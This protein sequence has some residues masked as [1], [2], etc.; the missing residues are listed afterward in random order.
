MKTKQEIDTYLNSLELPYFSPIVELKNS[1][2]IEWNGLIAKRDI[3]IGE[4][5][6]INFWNIVK[7]SIIEEIN[8]YY[9]FQN[10]LCIDFETYIIN[11]PFTKDWG[12][13]INHSCKPNCWLISENIIIA[14]LDIKVW[15]ECT[16]DYWTFETW[17][18]WKMECLCW[19]NNCRKIITWN[20]HKIK[21]LQ[22]N[23][24]KYFSPYLKKCL[25]LE[26]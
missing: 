23:L 15:D 5:L 12:W 19:E 10:N 18:D 9:D 14:I 3:K 11:K 7:K 17:S 21:E 25:N 4:I 22:I 8:N 20:D 16:I 6:V 2:T 13:Y 24:W 26:E 1:F